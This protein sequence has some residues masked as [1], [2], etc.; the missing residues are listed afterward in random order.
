MVSTP[1]QLGAAERDAADPLA[2]FRDRFVGAASD[3]VYF[4]GN[5]LG[6]PVAATAGRLGAFV[7]QDWGG[8]LIRGWDEQWMDLPT[9]LGDDLARVCLGAAAGQTAVGDSTTVLLYK[10]MRAAV[11]HAG[12]RTRPHRDRHRHRQLPHRP[13]R[14]RGHRRR[15][16]ADPAVD[17]GR[18][19]RG[20]HRRPAPRGGRRAHRPRR[21]QPRRV[22]LGLARRRRRSSPGSATTP[23][24][25]SS[26]T[27]ATPRARCPIALDEWDADLAVGCTYKYLNGG[28]GSPAFGYVDDAPAGPAH[29]ADPGLDGPR[30]PVPDGAGLHARAGHPE[31]HLR[32]PADPR[33]GRHAGHA[34]AGRGGGH[35]GDPR[36]VGRT[37]VVRRRARRRSRCPTSSSPRRATRPCGA[38]T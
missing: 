16:W 7:E 3:L 9:T 24:R 38:A 23:A 13:V 33:H 31:V 35:G 4:D 22:P 11:D 34:R 15:A 17:R 25:W 19:L 5:S 14:R 37:D 8:R 20:R 21:A 27:C 6:R 36:Q 28:P 30:R 18:H 26:G 2:R 12:A 1:I 29:P 10:L 32:D